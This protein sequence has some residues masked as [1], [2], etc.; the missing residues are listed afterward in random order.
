M[1]VFENPT[2]HQRYSD[3]DNPALQATPGGTFVGKDSTTSW[4]PAAIYTDPSSQF[5][6][7][8][9][10]AA[11]EQSQPQLAAEVARSQGTLPPPMTEAQRTAAALAATRGR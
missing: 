2:T 11:F 8:G 4:N 1:S 3:F 9:A 6:Q 7:P 5:Y 10:Q